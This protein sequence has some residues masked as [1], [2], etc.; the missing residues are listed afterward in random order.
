MAGH[1]YFWSSLK[2]KRLCR[3]FLLS[4]PK[5]DTANIEVLLSI[6]VIVIL[7]IHTYKK[8][9]RQTRCLKELKVM[10]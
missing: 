6:S 9:S 4:P 2:D 7:S 3:A 10:I 8:K 5:D 1:G